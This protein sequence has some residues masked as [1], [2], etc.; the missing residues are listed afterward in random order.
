M[1]ISDHFPTPTDVISY[2]DWQQLREA[3]WLMRRAHVG[4]A[5]KLYEELLS[6]DFERYFRDSI[7]GIE[8]SHE[9]PS[10][11]W[12]LVYLGEYFM[13]IKVWTQWRH[14]SEFVFPHYETLTDICKS[15]LIS[16]QG[17]ALIS[18]KGFRSQ[19][20][21]LAQRELLDTLSITSF[22]EGLHH[23]IL[24]HIHKLLRHP[25]EA[26]KHGHAA[27]DCFSLDQ[28]P[29]YTM[30]STEFLAASYYFFHKD[31]Q[32][33]DKKAIEIY[34]QVHI[35]ADTIGKEAETEKPYYSQGWTYL[36]TGNLEQAS[37]CFISARIIAMRH[38]L[39]FD[40]A[41][42]QYGEAYLLT[43][44]NH[45]E[46]AIQILKQALDVFWGSTDDVVS[47]KQ[48][49]EQVSILM[50]GICLHVLALTYERIGNL[51]DALMQEKKALQW[52]RQMDMPVYLDNTIQHL[53]KLYWKNGLW[54]SS[55]RYSVEHFY[56]NRKLRRK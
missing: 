39:K 46:A 42:T 44:S 31:F 33:Y 30:R 10:L 49:K 2:G 45:P 24:S 51:D 56:L 19:D 15:R 52:L 27:V 47:S 43:L 36:E 12:A 1:P 53:T 11:N 55:I 54:L 18:A 14:L 16:I 20:V 17:W 6:N 29:F 28:E 48:F 3:H 4:K 34:Q 23:I 32:G 8:D 22:E 40:R 35:M 26:L 38:N 21:A 25:K 41:Y 9:T 7:W 13:K 37:E 50:T 5:L